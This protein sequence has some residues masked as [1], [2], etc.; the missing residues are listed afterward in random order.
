[1]NKIRK[2]V[3]EA[4]AMIAK[5]KKLIEQAQR[6]CAHEDYEERTYSLRPGK[7]SRVNMCISCGKRLPLKSYKEK[8][9]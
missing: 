5:G 8:K 4:Q 9:A 7:L 1:M 3:E 6:M 2:Q